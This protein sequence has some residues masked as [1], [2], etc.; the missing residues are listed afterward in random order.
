V[1]VR[2]SR[3]V[4]MGLAA[5]A[6]VAVSGALIWGLYQRRNPLA[7][8]ELYNTENKMTPDGL[9][10][11]PRDYTAVARNSLPSGVPPLGKPLPSDLGRPMVNAQTVPAPGAAAVDPQQ[12]RIA[13]EIRRHDMSSRLAR[14]F[15]PH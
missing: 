9:S 7:G 14:S 11:L 4:L 12:Q 6:V 3:K 8:T 13:Q 2:L 5:I 1:V 15:P 10:T